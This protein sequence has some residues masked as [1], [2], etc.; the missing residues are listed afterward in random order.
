MSVQSREHTFYYF[1]HYLSSENSMRA[2]PDVWL[3]GGLVGRCDRG[4]TDVQ[5]SDITG[6]VTLASL[7]E[8]DFIVRCL[9]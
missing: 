8:V 5:R 6:N 9:D 2:Q 1:S 3:A 7:L 4:A